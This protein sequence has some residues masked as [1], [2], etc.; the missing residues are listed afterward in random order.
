MT[1]AFITKLPASVNNDA[2][3]VLG[4]VHI[5]FHK[6]SVPNV[7]DRSIFVKFNDNVT[8]KIAGDGYFTD[9]SLS[10]NKGKTLDIPAYTLTKIT[11]SNDDGYLQFNK[12]KIFDLRSDNNNWN[13]LC[14]L[15]SFDLDLSQLKYSNIS[16]LYLPN[17]NVTGDISALSNMTN[18]STLFLP[19]TNVTGDISALSNMTNMSTL[20]LPNTNV[21]GDI[22]ALSNLTTTTSINFSNTNVMGDISALS[23]LTNIIDIDFSHT[24]VTG[25]ISSLSKLTKLSGLNMVNC[26]VNGVY[27][28]FAPLI[29]LKSV[30]A[31]GANV[32]INSGTLSK[33]PKS[34]QVITLPY[35]VSSCTWNKGERT[36]GYVFGS[37]AIFPLSNV[38]DFLIDMATCNKGTE[39]NTWA[40]TINIKGNRT[41]ASDSALAK[42]QELG[43]TVTI[44]S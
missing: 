39:T 34:L 26:S 37:N 33:L 24:N 41:S 12:Y 4:M 30:Q 18:M 28:D 1:K 31:Y 19:N 13:P 15:N 25:S 11:V 29:S 22:S 6:Q 3:P 10:T 17:T 16:T 43:Y 8:A 23:N 7:N 32:K 14:T 44:N 9:D 27:D 40:H 42:L 5:P 38:D 20:F 36:N 35:N 21:M 2:L